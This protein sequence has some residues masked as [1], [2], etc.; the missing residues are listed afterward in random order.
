MS[1]LISWNDHQLFKVVC[2]SG[3]VSRMGPILLSSVG[4]FDPRKISIFGLNKKVAN[5]F[6][7][8]WMGKKISRVQTAEYYFQTY[9]PGEFDY[10]HQILGQP[11]DPFPVVRQ[12]DSALAMPDFCK[13]NSWWTQELK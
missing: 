2:S 11:S 13:T 4:Y 12:F 6:E 7:N 3:A 5:G 10:S 8:T 9:L 1:S